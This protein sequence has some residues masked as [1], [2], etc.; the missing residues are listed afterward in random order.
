MVSDGADAVNT[1][2]S[3]AALGVDAAL[4]GV[5]GAG[6]GSAR[7]VRIARHAGLAHAPVRLAVLAVSVATARWLADGRNNGWN[8]EQIGVT[9]EVGQAD[10]EVGGLVAPGAHSARDA[11]A[12]LLAATRH[13][14]LRLLAGDCG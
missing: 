4:G 5:A 13:A 12:T 14:D 6:L 8:A 11:L 10:A 9:D 3:V 1:V 2:R 7:L